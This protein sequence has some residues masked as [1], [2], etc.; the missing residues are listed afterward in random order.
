MQIIEKISPMRDWSGAARLAGE[1]IAF[2][3]TMGALHEGHLCL[4]RDAKRRADRVVVSIFVNPTQFGPHEDFG[5][6][7]RNFER[8]CGLLEKERIEVIFYPAVDEMFPH[9]F[10]THVEVDKLSLPLC[11]AL[12]PGHFR[13]VATVVAKLLNIV[14]PHVAIFGEKDY[15]QLQVIRRMVRDL[16]IETEIV[17]HPIVRDADG[18]A[19]SSRNAYLAPT[20]R[21]AALCLSRSLCKAERLFKRGETSAQALIGAVCAELDRE[22]LAQVEYVKLCDAETLDEVEMVG[23]RAVLALA[24]RIGKARLIDNRVLVH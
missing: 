16:D 13:G 14:R 7:P 11:G 21:Q 24:V 6:Y 17:S 9:Q 3:A 15:Q 4:V 1:R 5:G 23:D 20:E 18:L 10:Q 2:V 22:P 12:R 8:D 19:M